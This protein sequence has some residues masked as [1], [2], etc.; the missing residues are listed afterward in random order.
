MVTRQALKIV[1]YCQGEKETTTST[2]ASTTTSGEEN[3]CFKSGMTWSTVGELD[4]IPGVLSV[5][6]C[7]RI[8]L[9]NDKCE[10]YTWYGEIGRSK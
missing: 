10:G 4:F 6:D 9:E 1:I 3:N 7:A 8:C 5:Q 2:T